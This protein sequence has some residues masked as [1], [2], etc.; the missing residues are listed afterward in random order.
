MHLPV[1]QNHVNYFHFNVIKMTGEEFQAVL[2]LLDK[3]PTS[4]GSNGSYKL[5]VK[6]DASEVTNFV[7]PTNIS[8]K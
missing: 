7:V 8:C 2:E 6:V 3:V 1:Q 5:C 4:L